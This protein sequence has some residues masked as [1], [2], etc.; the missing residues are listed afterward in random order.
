MCIDTLALKIHPKVSIDPCIDPGIEIA[1][2]IDT[3]SGSIDT[4]KAES[5]KNEEK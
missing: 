2:C 3:P 4:Y 5:L 1:L